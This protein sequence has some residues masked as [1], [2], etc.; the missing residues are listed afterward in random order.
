VKVWI[1][2]GNYNS[3][4]HDGEFIDSIY[5]SRESAEAEVMNLRS[6]TDDDDLPSYY[7]YSAEVLS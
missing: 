6:G 1:V 2:A 7:V 5:L 4:S 3:M